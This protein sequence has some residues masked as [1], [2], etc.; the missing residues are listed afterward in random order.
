MRRCRGFARASSPSLPN[1]VRVIGYLRELIT[2]FDKLLDI[3]LAIIQDAYQAEYLQREKQL[4]H[5]RSEVKFR[6]LVEAAGCMVVILR[7][8][9]TV[10]YFSPYSEELT[11]YAAT[12]VVGQ[13]FQSLLIPEW[14]REEVAQAVDAT[15]AGRPTN[16]YE[17][18][19]TC[20]D[21]T[22]R[23]L[24]WNTRRSGKL[25]S[26]AGRL[27]GRPRFYRLARSRKSGCCKP[28]GL[29]ASAKWSPASP[30]KAATRC[31]GSNPQ[32]RC[33]RL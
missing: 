18:P 5:E 25:R 6:L 9:R 20:R 1:R 16:A 17:S 24:V 30:T 13:S 26:W 14:A 4:E 12:D 32:P 3:D 31:S 28:S 29:P 11:G 19:L 2:S 8:D 15:F 23:W 22:Q 33:W 21:G 27:G 7:P 10:A